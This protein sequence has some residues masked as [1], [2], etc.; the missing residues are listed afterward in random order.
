MKT[1]MS[2]GSLTEQRLV[3]K[4]CRILE[5]RGQLV[6]LSRTFSRLKLET[7]ELKEARNQYWPINSKYLCTE[8]ITRPHSKVLFH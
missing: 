8:R 6:Y 2:A 1:S 3:T 7:I 5:I 4:L